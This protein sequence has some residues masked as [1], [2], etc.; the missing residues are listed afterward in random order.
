MYKFVLPT[1][2]SVELVSWSSNLSFYSCPA[3][4]CKKVFA[5]V[6]I[7]KRECH[8]IF[9]FRFFHESAPEYTIGAVSNLRKFNE[10][11]PAQGA[12]IVSLTPVANGKNLQSEK[13]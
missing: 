3:A 4:P 2:D 5:S 6:N 13:K 1:K 12:P 9:N 7:L 11:F 10:I 8:E